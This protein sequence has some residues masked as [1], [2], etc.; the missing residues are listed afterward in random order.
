[1]FS[2]IGPVIELLRNFERPWFICGGW[3]LDIFIGRQTRPHADIE[4][5][6]FRQDQFYLQQFFTG[7][8]QHYVLDSGRKPWAPDQFLELPVHEIYIAKENFTLEV[9]L[10]ERT[11][12]D[13]IYRRN[14]QITMPV[15]LAIQTSKEGVPFLAPEIVLLYKTKNTREKD[16]TDIDNVLPLLGPAQL[17][18]FNKYA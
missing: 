17:A 5:G 14:A 9:L 12:H 2:E 11:D 7:W 4:I 15:E 13:W 10:N 18:W 6:V 3:A 8:E 16:K 1:M